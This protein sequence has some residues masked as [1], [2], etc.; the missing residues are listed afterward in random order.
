[1]LMVYL[2]QAKSAVGTCYPKLRRE[3]EQGEKF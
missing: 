1:L 3:Q 2:T